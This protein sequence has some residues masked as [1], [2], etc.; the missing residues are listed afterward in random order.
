MSYQIRRYP[1][2]LAAS[3]AL[4]ALL[5]ERLSAGGRAV[6][7][8]GSSALKAYA[9]FGKADILWSR[10]QFV[11]SDERCV[12][13]DHPERNERAIIEAL[14]RS[15][16]TFHR[17]PAELGPEAAAAQMEAVVR[18][19]I[20]FDVVVLGLGE[21]AHTA[22]LFPGCD[23]N[24]DT[25]VAPVLNSPKPPP[26]RVTLTPKALSQT[27]L[28]VY[29]VT[30]VGKREALQKVLSGQNV[31]PSKITAPEILI[32]CDEAAYPQAEV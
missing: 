20:P 9:L 22:S 30:G 13:P 19:L 12:A 14:E 29:I 4:A 2:A 26:E 1:H 18:E 32:L 28:L 31:P 6:L 7:A 23:L 16:I 3:E 10:A 11:V 17:F 21:D 8:G 5:A 24:F 15:K 25:L 27:Q